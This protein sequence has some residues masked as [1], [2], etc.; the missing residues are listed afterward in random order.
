MSVW[1]LKWKRLQKSIIHF[2]WLRGVFESLG[3]YNL[4]PLAKAFPWKSTLFCFSSFP[5]WI[6][7]AMKVLLTNSEDSKVEHHSSS[8]SLPKVWKTSMVLVAS[9]RVITLILFSNLKKSLPC[10][11]EV[12]PTDHSYSTIPPLITHIATQQFHPDNTNRH[13]DTL[14]L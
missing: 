1:H 13:P 8:E 11:E 9:F 4:L 10:L 12:I 5:S 14:P 7:S 3:L 2:R 6:S